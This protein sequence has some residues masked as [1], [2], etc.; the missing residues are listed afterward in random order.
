MI[1]FQTNI[2][3]KRFINTSKFRTAE[4]V[5]KVCTYLNYQKTSSFPF[6]TLSYIDWRCSEIILIATYVKSLLKTVG[7]KFPHSI[8]QTNKYWIFNFCGLLWLSTLQYDV[9][10]V[11]KYI[12][13]S[14]NDFTGYNAYFDSPVLCTEWYQSLNNSK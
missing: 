8:T 6:L 4:Q 12:L 13:L 2:A 1:L 7:G 11:D 9:F 3:N 5:F 10:I 14:Y